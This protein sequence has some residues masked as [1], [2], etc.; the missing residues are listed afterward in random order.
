[1]ISELGLAGH[2]YIY[3]VMYVC[4]CTLYLCVLRASDRN[5]LDSGEKS[6][7][8]FTL[9]EVVGNDS[10]PNSNPSEEGLLLGSPTRWH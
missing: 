4:L 3:I 1:M 10:E 2:I 8:G 5:A 7:F 9:M 6:N